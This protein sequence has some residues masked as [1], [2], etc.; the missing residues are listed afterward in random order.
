MTNETINFSNPEEN[1]I[2]YEEIE[3]LLDGIPARQKILLLDACHSGEVDKEDLQVVNKAGENL[4]TKNTV[5]I[6]GKKGGIVTNTDD[7]FAA[8][9][10]EG[11]NAL[12]F[13]P[14]AIDHSVFTFFTEPVSAA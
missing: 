4:L 12:L 10:L 1:G 6:S 7:G 11:G 2:P 14:R 5:I 3:N 9:K 8:L 13:H